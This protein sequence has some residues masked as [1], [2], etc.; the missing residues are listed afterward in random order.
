MFTIDDPGG[1]RNSRININTE[2]KIRKRAVTKITKDFK[3]FS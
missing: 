3:T 2:Q 1:N